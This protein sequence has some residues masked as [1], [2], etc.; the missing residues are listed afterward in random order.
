MRLIF[1]RYLA[2]G[3]VHKLQLELEKDGVF[4]KRHV[5]AAGRSMG[6]LP[7]SR[8]A[9]FHLL[10]NRLYRGLIVHKGVAH[11]GT[12]AAII[13]EA[14]FEAAQ[15]LM[16]SNRRR[17]RETTGGKVAGALFSGRTRSCRIWE[18]GSA[19]LGSAAARRAST[20]ASMATA[21]I[22]RT[23]SFVLRLPPC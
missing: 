22:R 14:A 8:G 2:L 12:H 23:V 11:P 1:E 3:S 7:F 4:S 18:I 17:H 20:S 13:D 15:A 16:A 9:L 5:T 6:G 21:G 10:S 19:R